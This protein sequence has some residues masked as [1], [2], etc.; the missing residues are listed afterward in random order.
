MIRMICQ[1]K[2]RH[3]NKLL[4]ETEIQHITNKAVAIVSDSSVIEGFR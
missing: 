2:I 4:K 1:R 3:C